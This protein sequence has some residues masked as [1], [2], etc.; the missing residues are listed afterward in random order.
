MSPEEYYVFCAGLFFSAEDARRFQASGK[1]DDIMF[2]IE[3]P[4]GTVASRPEWNNAYYWESEAVFHKKGLLFASKEYL[5]RNPSK[6]N[7]RAKADG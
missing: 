4:D 2:E 3:N 5:R 7:L 6:R 1:L